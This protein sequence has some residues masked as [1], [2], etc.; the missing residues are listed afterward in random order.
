M[1]KATLVV[2]TNP[3]AGREDDYNDWYTNRHLGDV[4]EVPGIVSAKRLKKTGDQV[5]GGC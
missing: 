5:R 3:V 2:L 1:V 4:L